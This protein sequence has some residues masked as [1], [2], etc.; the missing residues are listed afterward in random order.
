MHNDKA[1]HRLIRVFKHDVGSTPLVSARVVQAPPNEE[2]GNQQEANRQ[3]QHQN[4]SDHN[5]AS[6]AS[7]EI[8]SQTT[9]LAAALE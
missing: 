4:D 5:L 9:N 6:A 8:C 3:K 1:Y 2:A 7:E